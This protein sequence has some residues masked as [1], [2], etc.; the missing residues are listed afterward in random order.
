MRRVR[1]IKKRPSSGKTRRSKQAKARRIKAIH[2]ALL[3]RTPVTEH[4]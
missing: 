4:P 2:D 1:R 3:A